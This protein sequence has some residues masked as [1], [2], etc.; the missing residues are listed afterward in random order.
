MRLP[1]LARLPE[2]LAERATAGRVEL[3]LH[4]P[5]GLEYFTG[6]FPGLPV[7][8]GVVQ[9]DWAVRL[10]RPRLR[11][12][13][14]FAAAEQVKFLSVIAPSARLTLALETKSDGSK[15]VFS[16]T[17]GAKKYSSGT[18]VFDQ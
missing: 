2:V 16:Y 6:H 5:P 3:D 10:A 4:V 9:I 15:L 17:G 13:G 18:L 1:E 8:P 12:A 11:L 14:G 7:L